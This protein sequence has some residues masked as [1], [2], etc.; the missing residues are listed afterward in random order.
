VVLHLSAT[1]TVFSKKIKKWIIMSVTFKDVAKL[2]NVSTQT[3]SRVT[4]DSPNVAEETRKK[5]HAAVKQLGYIPNKG[6]QILG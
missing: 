5:V 6:A 2:A 1:V 3:V 4:N